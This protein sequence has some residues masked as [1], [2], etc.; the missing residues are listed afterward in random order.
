[1]DSGSF[2]G[3][4]TYLVAVAILAYAIGGWVAGFLD[5]NTS[6]KLIL[7]GLGLGAL[8]HGISTGIDMF[9]APELEEEEE[10]EEEEE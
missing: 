7:E 3:K 8:R 6:I 2:T 4:K 5:I 1:M 9:K 10:P